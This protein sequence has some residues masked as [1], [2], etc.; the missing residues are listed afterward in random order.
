MEFSLYK[1]AVHCPIESG[2]AIRKAI[3]ES[4][5]GIIGDY[6]FCSYTVVGMGRSK[7]SD[8]SKPVYGEPGTLSA[9]KE[10]RIEVTVPRAILK[11]VCSAIRSV[12]PYEEPT[13]DIYPLMSEDEI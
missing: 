2:D 11:N 1:I 5:G 4:G 9:E 12:H 10:E 13:I 3:G 8:K 7:G 6:S